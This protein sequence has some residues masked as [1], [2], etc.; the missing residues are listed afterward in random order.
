[1]Y[2]SLLLDQ[3]SLVEKGRGAAFALFVPF[4]T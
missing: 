1:M 4:F 2:N 3:Q